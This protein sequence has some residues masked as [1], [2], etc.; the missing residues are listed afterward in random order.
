MKRLLL[1]CLALLPCFSLLLAQTPGVTVI[2]GRIT[3]DTGNPLE[4]ASVVLAGSKK[5]VQTDPNG[6]F[7][8]SVPKDGHRHRISVSYVGFTTQEVAIEGDAPLSVRLAHASAE[9][10]IVIGYQRVQRR[11]LTGAVSSVT[12]RQLKD[13]P[14]NSAAD[15]LSGRLAGVE[16]TSDQ[17]APGSDFVV[18]SRGGGSITQDNSPL[19]IVDGV[20][21][22]NALSFLAPQDIASIDFLKDA[23]STAIYGARGANGVMIITTKGGRNTN[24][25]MSISYNGLVGFSELPKELGVMDPYNYV[26]YQWERDH[27][28]SPQDS[29]VIQMYAQNWSD[30][31]SYK[32]KP[33]TDWQHLVFGRHAFF[34]TH[35]V[36]LNGGNASTQYNVSLTD[37]EQKGIM[38][39]SVFSRKLANFRLDQTVTDR[40]KVGI[41]FR[42]NN[43]VVDGAGTTNGET[44]TTSSVQSFSNLRQTVRYTPYIFGQNPQTY[45]GAYFIDGTDVSAGNS[46]SL[47]NPILLSAAQYRRNTT[48]VLDMGG[49]LNYTFTPWL[50]FR[51]TFGYDNNNLRADA[52]DDTL[53]INSKLNGASLPIASI[54][55]TVVS[56]L[57]NSNVLTYTNAQGTS[58]FAR[59]N[60]ISVLAGQEIYQ[61][62]TKGYSITTKYFPVGISAA[63]ALA[64]M[65]LVAPPVGSVQP[66]PTSSDVLSRIASFFGKVTY[67]YEKTFFATATLRADG[68]SKF[69]SQRMWGYFPSTSV[70]WRISNEPFFQKLKFVNDAKIR[71]TYG[72]A[73]N[74]RIPDFLYLTQFVT[75]TGTAPNTTPVGYGLNGQLNTGFAPSSLGNNLLQWEVTHTKNL[76]LDLS[77]FEGRL[78]ST[79]DVYWD[80]TQ[81]LLIDNPS[82]PTSSGYNNQF[83]NIGSTSNKG[84]EEQLSGFPV[85]RK[86]FS[87]NVSFNI[88][89]NKNIITN[90]GGLPPIPVASGALGTASDYIIQKGQPVGSMYGYLSDGFYQISDFN[91]NATTQTYTLKKGVAND[92]GITG[93]APQPGVMKLKGLNGDSAIS[94]ADRTIIGNA[95]PKFFGGI[96]Q[97]FIWKNFDASVFVNFS[98]GNKIFDANRIEF[99]SGYTPGA[100][101][102]SVFDNRW[103]NVDDNGNLVKD[104]VALAALNKNATIWQPSVSG[105]STV[106]NPISWA[107]EDGSFIRLNNVSI[108]YTVQSNLL[109]RAKVTRLRIYVTGNNLYVWTHYSGYDPEVNTRRATPTTPGVDYS[110]YPRSRNY[111]FGVNL[112]L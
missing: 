50:S 38:L 76:G 73:G 20:Q 66:L 72:T 87:W 84:V 96:N 57:N 93:T 51:S 30:V 34:E 107:V 80:N 104:P 56:T 14:I 54:T 111:V 82:L 71:A 88:S 47:I 13:I 15:A 3:D 17:G 6:A 90:I 12:A 58:R 22:D 43:Q 18:K 69:S 8:L 91:Y 10:E 108:G 7:T 9:D 26:E 83:Q 21:V 77:L 55:T 31:A 81:K 28:L 32:T 46:L 53:T 97:Q 35:N 65:N 49:Y 24:G 70:A 67:D 25:K 16:V 79:T 11:D 75:A 98:Y 86:N 92:V 74:N 85:Q 100:N 23:A 44:T 52:F 4:G 106:F 33:A 99:S 36:S 62:E 2:H 5:G 110:A 1:L 19:Y 89:F 41:S 103:R 95:Q 29:A 68:S 94:A 61:T 42:Y 101:L 105:S 60:T 27:Y 39:N 78:T 112:T 59:H 109:R 63:T 37:N 64:N 48:N 45:N 40:L 102:L